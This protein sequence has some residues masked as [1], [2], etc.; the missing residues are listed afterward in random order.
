MNHMVLWAL[1]TPLIGT[2]LGAAM[3]FFL[4]DEIK[5]KLKKDTS[6]FCFRSHDSG[7]CM[8]VVD[9][10][11]RDGGN[12]RESLCLVSGERWFFAR[13]CFFAAVGQLCA[14]SASGQ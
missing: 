11:H 3:V 6:R 2:T 7:E 10:G 1:I 13:H 4:K 14:S 5:P 8:V 12:G 9:S